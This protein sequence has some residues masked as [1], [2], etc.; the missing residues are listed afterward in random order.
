[1]FRFGINTGFA[2]NSYTDP[3][4]WCALVNNVQLTTDL[5]NRLLPAVNLILELSF[6]E[7]EPFD[8]FS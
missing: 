4:S 2:F 3:E 1:M 8:S 5:I 6:K 7:R